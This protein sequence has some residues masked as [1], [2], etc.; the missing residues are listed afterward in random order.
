MDD[1]DAINCQLALID[2]VRDERGSLFCA[3]NS[4]VSGPIL[5]V[6]IPFDS[7]FNALSDFFWMKFD[8]MKI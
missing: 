5:N 8:K 7:S 3:D 1:D 6:F 4:L 2:F